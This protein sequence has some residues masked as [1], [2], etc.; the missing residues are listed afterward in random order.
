VAGRWKALG[1]SR[2]DNEGTRRLVQAA[3]EAGARAI[4]DRLM[5]PEER[6]RHRR[7]ALEKNLGWYLLPEFNGFNTWAW[8]PEDDE[9][10][11]TLPAPEVALRIGRTLTA[12]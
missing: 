12:V 9:L 7:V 6:E 10:E 3:A 11:R 8:T 4:R 5:P 1:V 2:T